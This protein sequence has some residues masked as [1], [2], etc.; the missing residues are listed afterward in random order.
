MDA[1]R[2]FQGVRRAWQQADTV[3]RQFDEGRSSEQL[4]RRW[5]LFAR[6]L[7][8]SAAHL[9][10]H[11]T[12]ACGREESNLHP[13]RDRDLNPARLPVPPRPR[14]V[15]RNEATIPPRSGQSTP[16]VELAS[17]FM[18]VQLSLELDA[19]R[20]CGTMPTPLTSPAAAQGADR[21]P[22]HPSIE[23]SANLICAQLLLLEAEYAERDIRST[24]TR[25]ADRSPTASPSTTRCNSSAATS[26]RS[27][28]ASPLRWA[29]SCCAPARPA[30]A[31][32]CHTRGS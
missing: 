23:T 32:P 31:S 16:R 1:N 19:T 11:V 10:V 4:N 12:P 7:R 26:R 2:L 24:S 18:P 5:S 17:R 9:P 13:R 8:G 25:R 21:L 15:R 3:R 27:A 6:M 20:A 22:R 30:S 28:L 29:S 14:A